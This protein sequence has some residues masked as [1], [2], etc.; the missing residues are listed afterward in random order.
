M[1]M[2]TKPSNSVAA[3]I[4]THNRLTM[5]KGCVAHL[6]AQ[7]HPVDAILVVDNDSRDGTRE[8]LA[9]EPGL[10]VILQG[11]LG[12]AGGF[13][14]GMKSA[15]DQGYDWLWCMDDD[16][17]PTAECLQR[18][19]EVDQPEL[20]YRAPLVLDR[21]NDKALAFMLQPPDSPSLLTTRA[22]A[23]A[24][25]KDGLIA[26]VA[27]PFN[28]VLIQRRVFQTIGFP[29]KEMFMWGDE[30]EFTVRA[31]KAGFVPTTCVGA[32]FSHPRDRMTGQTFR[33]FGKTMGVACGGSWLR[34]YVV[35][36]NYG[37]L[38][39]KWYGWKGLVKHMG[40]YSLFFLSRRQPVRALKSLAWSLEGICGKWHG[41][42]RFLR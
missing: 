34:D 22:D 33:C 9:G 17:Y 14:A 37:Y 1:A 12:G 4:V 8:W 16:G 18:L 28:G 20:L 24:A 35:V 41:H 31:H 32:M 3:V 23:V 27:C 21:D 25:A 36:R 13:Y 40:R 42:E 39:K 10:Q 5:L 30:V 26:G 15:Y 6:R 29:L 11:N 19:L 2:S 38:A 7:T